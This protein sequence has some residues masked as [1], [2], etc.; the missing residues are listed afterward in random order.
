MS[1]SPH[2]GAVLVVT[3]VIYQMVVKRGGSIPSFRRVYVDN[4]MFCVFLSLTNL[5][6]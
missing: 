4:R 2:T 1:I 3:R 6:R 5:T